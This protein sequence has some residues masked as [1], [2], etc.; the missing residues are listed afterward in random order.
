MNKRKYH[1]YWIEDGYPCLVWKV[2]SDRKT[3][4][5][6]HP[7]HAESLIDSG[8]ISGKISGKMSPQVVDKRLNKS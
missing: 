3:A 5:R 1:G 7:P 2:G 6:C 4:V 8:A